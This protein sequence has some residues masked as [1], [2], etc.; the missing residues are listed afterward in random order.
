ML[1]SPFM[2]KQQIDFT[3]VLTPT[4]PRKKY[5]LPSIYWLFKRDPYNGLLMTIIIPTRTTG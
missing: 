3:D 5:M 4:E 1:V 2:E